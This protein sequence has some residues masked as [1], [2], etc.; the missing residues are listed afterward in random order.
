MY[1]IYRPLI[2]VYFYAIRIA[3]IFRKDARQWVDGRAAWK[4]KSLDFDESYSTSN[5]KR[6]WFHVSSLGEFEQGRELIEIIRR[7]HQGQLIILSFFSPS[8]FEKCQGYPHVDYTCYFPSD[9]YSEIQGFIQIIKPDLAIFVKYDFWFNTLDVLRKRNIPYIYISTLFRKS[10]F[11]L[12]PIFKSL[13]QKLKEA[14]HIFL[15]NEE[16]YK[17]LQGEGFRN[18]QVVGDTRLDRVFHIAKETEKGL[19]KALFKNDGPIFIAGSIWKEDFNTIQECI[20]HSLVANWKIILVPHKIEDDLILQIESVFPSQTIRYTQCN[21]PIQQ[22]ILII[23]KIGLLSSLYGIAKLAYV[24]GGFGKGIHN[25]LEPVAHGIPVCFGPNY[26]K[27][28]E[29]HDFLDVGIASVIHDSKELD[30]FM[31]KI[32]QAEY[33]CAVKLSIEKY[34]SKNLGASQKIYQY[35]ISQHFL[36]E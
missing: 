28:Q 9:R 24:G 11:L 13:L 1:L 31:H 26:S 33:E 18:L 30:A 12:N 17:F 20:I 25:I 21:K 4:Q 19:E 34:F 35:L 14:N 36:D 2:A 23:D 7:N 16:S 27:F 8:G 32:C 5:K 10:H 22:S 3:A 29:A 15:Q 6:I